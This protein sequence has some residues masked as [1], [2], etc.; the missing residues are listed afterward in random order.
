MTADSILDVA[1]FHTHFDVLGV[2]L[3]LVLLYEYGLRRL[4]AFH[5]PRGEVVVTRKQR[6]AFYA[7]IVSLYLVSSWPVHDI[8]ENSLFMFHM[9]EHLVFGLI[10]PPLLLVGTPWWLI[11][12]AVR[13]VLPVLKV[14]T[15]P[16]VALALFNGMLGLIH[17]PAVLNLMLESE[18][19][20]FGL[21]AVLFLTGILMW[22]PVIGPIPDIP[23]LPPFLRMGYVFLQSLVPTI[24]A[25]FL[26]FGENPLYP[27]YETFPRLWGIS[28]LDDQVLAGLIMKLG[29]GI[30]L[31]GYIAWIWFSWWNDEQRYSNP[32]PRIGQSGGQ[33]EEIAR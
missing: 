22:W 11:R 24:P 17:A 27:V 13:P 30:L 19:A 14:L 25:T 33:S 15:K 29:A 20:H 10:A 12:L 6:I 7:G 16:L 21:H 18:L 8:G 26:T 23:Q 2:L 1:P 9:V 32:T 4:A 3:A 28:A 31:W 5:A